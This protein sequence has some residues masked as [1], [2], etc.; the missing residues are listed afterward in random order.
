MLWSRR[1]SSENT[2]TSIIP[3]PKVAKQWSESFSSLMTSNCKQVTIRFNLKLLFNLMF[4]NTDGSALFRAFL[5]REFN[6]ENLDF[7]LAVEDYKKSKPQKML[8]KSQK[9]YSNFVAIEAPNEVI[10][11]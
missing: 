9:I 3:Q 7:W 4:L 5:L 6:H 2:P 1:R 8:S 10:C 11:F